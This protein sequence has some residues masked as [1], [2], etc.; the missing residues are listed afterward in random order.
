MLIA[1][2]YGTKHFYL[3]EAVHIWI[4]VTALTIFFTEINLGSIIFFS[5]G[6]SLN[7]YQYLC[8]RNMQMIIKYVY[9]KN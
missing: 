5:W 8:F 9:A 3:H 1:F 6:Q 2:P 4:L 7:T